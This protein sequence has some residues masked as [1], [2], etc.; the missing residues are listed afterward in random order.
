MQRRYAASI[1]DYMK[2]GILGA[3]S[4]GHRLGVTWWRY[5][6]ESHNKDGRP[7]GYLGQSD[8]WRHFDPDLLDALGQ[9]VSSGQRDIR[10]LEAANIL[11]GAVFASDVIPTGG[12]IM[13][14]PQARH[15][16]FETVQRTLHEADLVFVDPNNGLDSGAATNRS[17]MASR[18]CRGWEESTPR[19]S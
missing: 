17:A 8:Q 15:E 5:A 6:D 11:A 13:R 14:R 1:G 2:L 9:I 16:W 4:P 19:L 3:L 7:I 18:K 12:S 10:V